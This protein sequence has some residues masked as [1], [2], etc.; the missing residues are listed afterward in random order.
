MKDK[1]L[2]IW[3]SYLEVL[4]EGN[5][6]G[7]LQIIYFTSFI[8]LGIIFYLI[9]ISN[10]LCIF[11][12]LSFYIVFNV[13]LYNY[14]E[15]ILEYT[16]KALVYFISSFYGQ[17]AIFYMILLEIRLLIAPSLW[18]ALLFA[19]PLGL[20]LG[21]IEDCP[22]FVQNFLF[23][24]FVIAFFWWRFRTTFFNLE[25]LTENSVIKTQEL[26]LKWSSFILLFN[27][28]FANKDKIKGKPLR[29]IPDRLTGSWAHAALN[30]YKHNPKT[31]AFIGTGISAFVVGERV[32]NQYNIM[33]VAEQRDLELAQRGRE[34]DQRSREL[35]M[36]GYKIESDR[37]IELVKLTNQPGGKSNGILMDAVNNSN[38]QIAA[39]NSTT[40]VEV[41]SLNSCLETF[42]LF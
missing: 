26:E 35:S 20:T 40:N 22:F 36:Q 1:L 31:V 11:L 33:K 29:K 3:N 7:I 8:S 17:L 24:L 32:S 16:D 9:D 28:Y 18:V 25:T 30:M 38:K 37:N 27:S 2:K 41:T 19:V 23:M 39:M 12:Y 6:L 10:D 5:I 4:K 14:K 21:H 13:F 42:F 34:I 15:E